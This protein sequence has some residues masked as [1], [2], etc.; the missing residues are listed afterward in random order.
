M[1]RES[2]CRGRPPQGRNRV[3]QPLRPE[4]PELAGTM[5][6]AERHRGRALSGGRELS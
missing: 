6:H 2:E 4:F 5:E 1:K 3:W